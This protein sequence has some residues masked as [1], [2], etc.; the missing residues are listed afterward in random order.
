MTE[1]QETTPWYRSLDRTKW[2]A[3]IAANLGWL[4]D[5]FETYALILT[6]GF[7]LRQLHPDGNPAFYIGLTIAMTLLGW[8][9][10]GIIGGI[11]ADYIGRRKV[12]LLSITLYSIFT[13]L[14]A[15][16][17]NW[18]SF[19]ILRLLTGVTLGSEWGTG[20]S[21]VAEMWP[22]H[23]RAKAAGLMQCGLG[24]GFFVA[25]AAWHFI[26]PL[27]ADSWR[28]MFLLGVLPAFFALW[29][30]RGVPESDKWTKV[31]SRRAALQARSS[32]T[33]E[34]RTYT[35][36][37]L[38]QILADPALRR[39]TIL[40]SIMSTVTTL[41][42]WGIST[43]VPAYVGSIAASEG[44]SPESYAS[45][46]G[47][48]YNVGAIAGYI[49]L[50]FAAD[51]FGRKGTV[52]TYF[53]ASLIMTPV[54]FLWTSDLTLVLLLCAVNGFFTLGQYTWMPVWLP[55]FY[56]THL[57]ATGAAFVFNAARFIAFLGPLLAGTIIAA[58]GGYGTA[59]TVLG[60]IYIVGMVVVPFCPETRGR[61]LP[62]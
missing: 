36:F 1:V 14:S 47:M 56:P 3:L 58:F 24:L 18:E 32:L 5:G 17:W 51:R 48:I 43:W 53:A 59:A 9:A 45:T 19:L 8:G 33:E 60:L 62:E 22:A 25:S 46:A 44:R 42:W 52:F 61:A 23:A 37:T 54:L 30:R 49:S 12:L 16:A 13:G 26:A 21:L 10:G 4:F 15:F 28:Y 35:K 11:V 57:R 50:G 2:R 34:E 27:G 31:A 6:A 39:L 20:T 55:E 7:A 41:A 29:L 40:G 38:R